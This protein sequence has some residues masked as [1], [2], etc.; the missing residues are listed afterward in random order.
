MHHPSHSILSCLLGEV[1]CLEEV[2]PQLLVG[3]DPQVPLTDGHKNG[4]MRDGVGGEMIELHPVIMRDGP[5]K[6]ARWHPKTPPMEGDEADHV[7]LR[8]RRFSVAGWQHPPLW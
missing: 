7:A 1:L 6:S 4:D 8:W 5:H 3:L 2:E